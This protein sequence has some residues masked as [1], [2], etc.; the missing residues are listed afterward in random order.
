MLTFE[1]QR[2]EDPVLKPIQWGSMGT[3]Y[4]TLLVNRR[5]AILRVVVRVPPIKRS[6]V[7]MLLLLPN[8]VGPRA[9]EVSSDGRSVSHSSRSPCQPPEEL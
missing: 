3:F 9:M 4:L 5:D 2:N 6:V 7:I 8:G 1:P